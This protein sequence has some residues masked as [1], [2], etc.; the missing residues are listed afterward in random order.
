MVEPQT[1]ASP[2]PPPAAP[3]PSRDDGPPFQF[4]VFSLF[5][6]MTVVAVA[7]ALAPVEMLVILIVVVLLLY[8]PTIALGAFV[9]YARG[10]KQT[11]ALG[12]LGACLITLELGGIGIL[13]MN[14][15]GAEWK[16]YAGFCLLQLVACVACGYAALR[17]RSFVE[18]RGWHLTPASTRE[19]SGD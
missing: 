16:Y 19:N 2:P 18:S 8:L 5:V 6:V 7:M 17:V 1:L 9:W 11:F 10:P 13:G 4:S 3:P 12:A 15:S 14:R